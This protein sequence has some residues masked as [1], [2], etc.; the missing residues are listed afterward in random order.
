MGFASGESCYLA[1]RTHCNMWNNVTMKYVDTEY[2]FVLFSNDWD[3][4]VTEPKVSLVFFTSQ[5]MNIGLPKIK[6]FP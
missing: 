5:G 3:L 4:T 2:S 1:N 6:T